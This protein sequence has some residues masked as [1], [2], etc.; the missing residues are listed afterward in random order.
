[1]CAG[2][3]RCRCRGDS[4]GNGPRGYSCSYVI[5]VLVRKLGHVPSANTEEM[6]YLLKDPEFLAPLQELCS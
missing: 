2:L 6:Y 5:K 1:M 3:R 4:R